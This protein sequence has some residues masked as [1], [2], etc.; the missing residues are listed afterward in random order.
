MRS[1][2]AAQCL[3]RPCTVSGADR[4]STAVTAFRARL[5]FE[6]RAFPGS[7]RS[8]ADADYEATGRVRATAPVGI[9]GDRVFEALK[10]NLEEHGV[11]STPAPASTAVGITDL[12]YSVRT[13]RMHVWTQTC[14][15]G[16]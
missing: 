15:V 4:A 5:P 2:S 16:R 9:C 10:D 13:R 6:G 1:A 14:R 7:V 12:A 11:N 8:P 3:K